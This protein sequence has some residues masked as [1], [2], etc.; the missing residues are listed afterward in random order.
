VPTIN[1]NAGVTEYSRRDDQKSQFRDWILV[2]HVK[3]IAQD[4]ECNYENR[5]Q[6]W[7]GKRQAIPAHVQIG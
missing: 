4:N 5:N 3:G 2:S 7:E 1:A 6:G